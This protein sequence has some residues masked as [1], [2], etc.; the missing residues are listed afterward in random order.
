MDGA[1]IVEQLSLVDG[2]VAIGGLDMTPAFERREHREQVGGAVA[3]VLV[4]MARRP[5]RRCLDRQP[6]LRDPLR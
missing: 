5:A 3:L 2:G 4:V 1:Q 6:R